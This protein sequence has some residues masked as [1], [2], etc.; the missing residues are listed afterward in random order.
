MSHID[1]HWSGWGTAGGDEIAMGTTDGE[2]DATALAALERHDRRRHCGVPTVS[3]LVGPAARALRSVKQWAEALGRPVVFL[4]SEQADPKT[5]IV[6]WVDRLVAEIDLADAAADW[7]ARRL[8]RRTDSVVRSLRAMTPHEVH[9]FLG[10][11]LP[12]VSKGGVELVGGYLAEHKGTSRQSNGASLAPA[13][14]LLLEGHGRP[15]FRV[16]TA[17]SELVRRED[18]PVLVLTA[19]E[20]ASRLEK[21]ARLFAEMAIAQPRVPAVLLVAPGLFEVYVAQAPRSRAKALLCEAVVTLAGPASPRMVSSLTTSAEDREAQPSES[22][23]SAISNRELRHRGLVLEELDED[24]ARSA[25]ERFLFERL[26]SLPNTA[27]LFE[28][29]A[30]LDFRFGPTN[31]V[32]VDLAARSLKLVVEV[33]GYHH[34]QDPEAYRR[35]R[36]KDLELQRRGYLVARVLAGDVVERLEEVIDMILAAVAHCRAGGNRP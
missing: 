23:E 9:L 26:E 34:F 22:V 13:L 31:W 14:D 36:R 35:D 8:G 28:L 11:V 30:A 5:V 21:I 24:E 15:W 12:L 27:G 4:R 25:A 19:G 18:L 7:L 16:L 2:A 10:S 29:N 32:E 6:S 3:V 20:D 1:P 17:L 33:D